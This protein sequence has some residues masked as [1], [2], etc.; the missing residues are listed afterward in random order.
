MHTISQIIPQKL[1]PSTPTR[2][3]NQTE[4][5]DVV[6][7]PVEKM[8]MKLCGLLF[9]YYDIIMLILFW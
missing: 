2:I 7:N 5:K 6:E 1:C 8:M 4:V 9:H 3:I